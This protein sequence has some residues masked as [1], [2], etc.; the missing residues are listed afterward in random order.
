M[1]ESNKELLK[2]DIKQIEKNMLVCLQN[3]K[4]KLNP[5]KLLI[6]KR[7]VNQKIKTVKYRKR[8][9]ELE[10]NNKKLKKEIEKAK[11]R[12]PTKKE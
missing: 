3:L 1:D 2:K 11:S 4:R 10:N 9:N 12:G 8:I 6:K 7:E 5:I